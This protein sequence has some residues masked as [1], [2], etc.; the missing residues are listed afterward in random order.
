M[1]FNNFIKVV[2]Y[3]KRSES[4]FIMK[5]T[6]V[7][8]NYLANLFEE[9]A[10]EILEKEK[11][12]TKK[13]ATKK[14]EKV[15]KAEI[16]EKAEKPKTVKKATKKAT[17]KVEDEKITKPAKKVVKKAEKPAEKQAEK[18]KK[19]TKAK[20]EKV[21]Q[22]QEK[23]LRKIEKPLKIAK[24]TYKVVSNITNYE[25]LLKAVEEE[26]EIAVAFD[27]SEVSKSDY[28]NI[29]HVPYVNMKDNF[30]VCEPV[31]IGDKIPRLVF[32]SIYSEALW[33]LFPEEFD[34]VSAVLEK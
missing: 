4:E 26:R 11:K 17:E 7:N 8:A 5:T 33:D 32:A 21:E 23:A 34:L 31:F 19:A 10:N 30:D 28:E 22:E 13:K 9:K 24:S 25:E 16:T 20:S 12:A 1:F 3:L 2:R 27:C 14:A 6:E 15:E 29:F 18:P